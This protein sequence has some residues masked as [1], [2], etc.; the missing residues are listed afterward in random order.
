MDMPGP[1]FSIE[2]YKSIFNLEAIRAA[3]DCGVNLLDTAPAYNAGE[4][5]RNVGRV[6]KDMGV[7][8]RMFIATKCGTEF[9]VLLKNFIK[10][11]HQVQY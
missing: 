4:T 6:L 10:V 3:V 5:E 1:S 7:R 2:L 11:F 8:Q 9:I